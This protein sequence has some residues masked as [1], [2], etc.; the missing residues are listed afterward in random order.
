MSDETKLKK[1]IADGKEADS[2]LN[3]PQYKSVLVEIRAEL[4]DACEK[5]KADQVDLREE[6]WRQ[7]R[8]LNL[9]VRKMERR[10]RDGDKAKTLL[11]KLMEKFK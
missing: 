4:F 2:W 5:T 8:A 1:A 3:H 7:N 10:V 6:I 11:E 9:I